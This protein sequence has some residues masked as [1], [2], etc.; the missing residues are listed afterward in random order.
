VRAFRPFA[1][2][3]K[4]YNAGAVR[5]SMGEKVTVCTNRVKVLQSGHEAQRSR[6]RAT[7]CTVTTLCPCWP[8]TPASPLW[9]EEAR[10]GAASDLV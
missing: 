9:A 7:L 2:G 3:A 10:A 8:S 4:R 6:W 1:L 5:H